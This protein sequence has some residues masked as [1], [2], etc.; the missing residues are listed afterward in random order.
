MNGKLVTTI[1]SWAIKYPNCQITKTPIPY[2]KDYDYYC[3][4]CDVHIC[5]SYGIY[6]KKNCNN[7]YKRY[8]PNKPLP[9]PE[10]E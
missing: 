4:R 3:R 6:G 10:V 9:Y 1:D 7:H 5:T 8:H 2:E